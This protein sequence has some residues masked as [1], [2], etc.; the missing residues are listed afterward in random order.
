[1]QNEP[2]F[3]RDGQFYVPQPSC[4]GPW[5]PQSLHGRVIVGLLGFEIEA[6][7][8]SPDFMPARLT[9]DMYR[10]PGFDPIEVKTTVVRDGN[11]IRVVD[12]E[13]ISGG[14]S[15]ARAS[16]QFLKRTENSPGESWH[17]PDWDVPK[18]ADIEPPTDGRQGMGGMW[19]MR[20]ITGGFGQPGPRK[21]WMSEVREMV[22][23]APLTPF[24][25]VSLAADFSSPFANSSTEGLGY[26]NSD[27]TVYLHRLPATE[28]IGFE[29]ADHHAT[30]GVAIGECWLY[31]EQGP[32]GQAS[33]AALAQRRLTPGAPPPAAKA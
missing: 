13:F 20:P 16:V 22:E 23:G 11:R 12:A 7:H 6:R 4:R 25:R 24:Q 15:M 31:D 33:C 2:F 28:W 1:M 8:G 18:P 27:V 19:A 26:I 9:V 21:T 30:D 10:L 14:V 17:R 3:K 32:I 29:V 5:N